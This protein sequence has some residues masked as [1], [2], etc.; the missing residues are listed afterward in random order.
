MC[1]SC[2]VLRDVDL[3]F[4]CIAASAQTMPAVLALLGCSCSNAGTGIS[5]GVAQQVSLTARAPVTAV[6]VLLASVVA[7]LPLAAASAVPLAVMFSP[8]AS[9]IKAKSDPQV[10][11]H[12]HSMS[13]LCRCA[14]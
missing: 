7:Q 11:G 1:H 4:A 3:W 2:L 8:D 14:W 10:C 9:C 5:S 6:G 12:H 13:L